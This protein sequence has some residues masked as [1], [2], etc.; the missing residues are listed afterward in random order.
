MASSPSCKISGKLCTRRSDIS[1]RL[2]PQTC[3]SLERAVHGATAEV[4]QIVP[5]TVDVYG[6]CRL[7]PGLSQWR[8]N[9]GEISGRDDHGGGRAGTAHW[10]QHECLHIFRPR[11][12]I[13]L[14]VDHMDRLVVIDIDSALCGV[15]DPLL[16]ELRNEQWKSFDKV[17]SYRLSSMKRLTVNQNRIVQ[18]NHLY[19]VSFWDSSGRALHS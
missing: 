12:N 10:D 2:M 3:G 14:G 11:V 19:Q 4:K 7:V 13:G 6:V 16:P 17:C 18:V 9:A 15:G 5:R 8:A 1:I